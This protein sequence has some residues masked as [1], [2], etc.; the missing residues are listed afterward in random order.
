MG[1]VGGPGTATGAGGNSFNVSRASFGQLQTKKTAQRGMMFP[2]VAT[3]Q[4]LEALLSQMGK[5]SCVQ[6]S[7]AALGGIHT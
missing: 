6:L 2:Q 3:L 5:K 7:Y 4:D 1:T